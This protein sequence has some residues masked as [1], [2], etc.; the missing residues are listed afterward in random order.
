MG[1]LA[2]VTKPNDGTVP[3]LSRDKR[4]AKQSL[5]LTSHKRN[6]WTIECARDV[7]QDDVRSITFWFNIAPQMRR[8]DIVSVWAFDQSWE[9]E[10]CI[11]RVKQ[12]SEVAFGVG[13]PRAEVSRKDSS[14][15]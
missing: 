3:S 8:L 4:A 11:E 7:T 6:E 10:V 2:E 13:S 15:L 9:M 12:P 14:G 1:E 5:V